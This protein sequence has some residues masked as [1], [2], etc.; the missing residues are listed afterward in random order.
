MAW[1]RVLAWFWSIVLLGLHSIPRSRLLELPGGERMISTSGSDK[2]AHLVI[3]GVFALLWS[4]C[5][6]NRLG[7]VV[8]A[9][10]VYGAALEVYQ[11]WLIAGR[12]GSL[13]DLMADTVGL[14]SGVVLFSW[15][16]RRRASGA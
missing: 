7:N 14:L 16:A 11:G 15:W 13:A 6:P 9:G 4:R 12:S 5:Y 1:H 3:F 8:V 10:L 2:A